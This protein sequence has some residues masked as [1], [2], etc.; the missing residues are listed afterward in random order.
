M[1]QRSGDGKACATHLLGFNLNKI[2]YMLV[3][4]FNLPSRKKLFRT[5]SSGIRD[6]ATRHI[7]ATLRSVLAFFGIAGILL[8]SG[9]GG[10]SGAPNNPYE[11]PPPAIPPLQVLPSQI[12]VYPGTPA[13]L[14]ISGGVPPYRAFSSDATVLPVSTN[15]SGNTLVLA[16]NNVATST[17]VTVAV[18]DSSTSLPFNVT[19]S[20]APAPLLPSLVTVNGNTTPGCD[21]TDN[22]VCSGSTGTA[23]VR[24]TGPG[25]NGIAGRS[26]RFDVV[27]GTYQLVSTNPAQ[28][29]VQTMTV[30]TDTNGDAVVVLSV[31]PNTPTQTGIIRATDLTSGQ[32]ITGTFLVQQIAVDGAVLAVL[33]L[34]NTTITGPDSSH[35]SSGVSVTNYIF[36]GTPPYNVGVN[37]PGAVTL[38]GVPVTQSGGAFTTVTNG[39]CFENLTYV[40]TDATGRTIPSGAYPTVTNELGSGAP[41]PPPSALVATPGAIARTN[42]V[43][44]NTFPFVGTGGLPPYFAVVISSS[45]TT[46]PAV[47]PQNNIT[48]GQAVNV[49]GITSP[50][51]TVVQLQD[52]SVPRQ[53]ATVTI[54]CSGSPPPPTPSPLVVTPQTQGNATTACLASQTYTFVIS[55]GTGPYN[56]FFQNPKGNPTITPATVSSSGQSFTISNLASPVA[57]GPNNVTI[58][59]SSTPALVTTASVVC[60]P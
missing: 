6:M 17:T 33:P 31:P 40:I 12:T 30:T 23:R 38:V 24:V 35:C 27:Q 28:P 42:C 53:S 34:G 21:S 55:G 3:A 50:S 1:R 58:V 13:T 20:V 11:P 37:F 56:L 59:D 44:A 18:Q 19:V 4:T 46:S 54:D 5:T 25:S 15:I 41:I 36:G 57:A 29:L 2:T 47:S 9:C 51:T 8:L 16:A 49:S 26:V 7:G 48:S 32:A 52:S 22:T 14:T 60:A 45:S 43:P 10:G 39:T